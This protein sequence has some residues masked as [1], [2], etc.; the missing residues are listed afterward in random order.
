MAKPKIL[1]V[2]DMDIS[3]Q[4]T[5]IA[6]Q[7]FGYECDEAESGEK[8]LEMVKDNR[9]ALIL[10]DFNM[11]GIDGSQCTQKIREMERQTGIRT[12]I[13][14]LTANT[15]SNVRERCLNSGMDDYIDKS[16]SNQE[17]ENL[18]VKWISRV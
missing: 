15:E 7:I 4:S 18:L 2:D 1:I 11:P 17:L 13:I 10:M 3:R 5:A 16:C 6:M 14:G 9:Y 8:G 12:P